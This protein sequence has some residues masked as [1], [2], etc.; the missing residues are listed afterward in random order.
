MHIYIYIYIYAYIYIYIYMRTYIC[1]SPPKSQAPSSVGIKWWGRRE[2]GRW[3][4][5]ID[6]PVRSEQK[7]DGWI[8]FTGTP[9]GCDRICNS[10]LYLLYCWGCLKNQTPFTRGKSEGCF[11]RCQGLLQIKAQVRPHPRSGVPIPSPS[12]VICLLI[13]VYS[14]YCWTVSRNSYWFSVFSFAIT[15]SSQKM[16]AF[17]CCGEE[18]LESSASSPSGSARV[19]LQHLTTTLPTDKVVHNPS[20]LS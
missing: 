2:L 7:N 3:L 19:D 15:C 11:P 10:Q 14:Q 8:R 13:L 4:R 1:T 9:L 6:K 16:S 17:H 18:T 12:K 20:Y 5:C